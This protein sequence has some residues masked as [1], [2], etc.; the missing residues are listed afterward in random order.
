MDSERQILMVPIDELSVLNPRARNR[1]QHQEI[2][3]NIETIGLKRPITVRQRPE[4]SGMV[5]Y[6]VICGE[7]RLEAF[8]KLGQAEVPVVVVDASEEDCLVMG[9]VENLARRQHRAI[10][11]MQEIGALRERGYNDAQI[12]EKIGLTPSYINMIVQLI[13]KGEE[14]LLSA[15][16]SGLIPISMA[17][18]IARADD[19]E[20]QGVLADAYAQGKIRGKK[21]GSVRRMLEQREKRSKSIP[22]NG[23]G[24]KTPRRKLTADEL[25]R[26]YQREAEKQQLIVKRSDFT[27][28]RLL[29]V[30]EAL[31]DLLSEDG[32]ITLLRAEGLAKMPTWLDEKLAASNG[33]A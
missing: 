26:L 17:I 8:R 6:D 12:A 28:S 15:V 4:R 32:F 14:R 2:V 3:D 21:L 22:D 30:I 20:V 23:L 11:L 9:L 16:E 31:R 13:T 33:V 19:S 18:D 24:R 29:F 5:R 27:R 1:R 10:D 7:G 25:M